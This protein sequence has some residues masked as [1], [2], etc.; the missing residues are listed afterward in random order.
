LTLV[1]RKH[2][3]DETVRRTLRQVGEPERDKQSLVYTF[4]A[5]DNMA[6][7]YRPGDS[8]FAELPVRK[9][10]RELKLTWM[11]PRTAAFQ[12]ESLT[13]EPRLH[14]LEQSAQE[15]LLAVGV[16]VSVTEGKFPTVPAM[17]P[18]IKSPK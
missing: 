17:V 1:L 16:K 11:N 2:G 4:A 7:A 14:D 18:A 15:G 9:G 5:T 6:M 3:V 8:F 12:F 13:R 10:S